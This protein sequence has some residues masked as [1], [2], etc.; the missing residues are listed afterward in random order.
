MTDL[1]LDT[2]HGTLA[3][4]IQGDG[5]PLIYL[6]GGE[7]DLTRSQPLAELLAPRFRVLTHDRRGL[8]RSTTTHPDDQATMDDHAADV[9]RLI[10]A[11][12]MDNPILVGSSFGAHLALVIATRR[13][14]R[15]VAVHEPAIPGIMPTSQQPDIR[16]SLR[17]IRELAATQGP[18]AA[19]PA[20]LQMVGIRLPPG[21][22]GK[23]ISPPINDQQLATLRRFLT[24]DI[25]AVL[26]ST[27]NRSD[28]ARIPAP[29]IALAG[30]E[31]TTVWNHQCA[32]E[33]STITNRGLLRTPG[34]HGAP[35]TNPQGI[36]DVLLPALETMLGNRVAQ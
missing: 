29:V 5:P 32:E 34:G 24:I 11:T 31:S 7:G 1:Q 13:P 33:I 10:A 30:A 23:P 25:E 6:A 36:A 16:H 14:V 26:N 18:L 28:I 12:G 22:D 3:A 27:L 35:T 19:M 8:G 9:D 15:A 21:P 20:M 17:R 4:R 2:P